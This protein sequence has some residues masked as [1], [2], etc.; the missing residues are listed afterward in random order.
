[1]CMNKKTEQS[2][3][4]KATWYSSAKDRLSVWQRVKNTLSRSTV[5]KLHKDV[6]KSRGSW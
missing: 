5:K 4:N 6:R 3:G 2:N 1:M